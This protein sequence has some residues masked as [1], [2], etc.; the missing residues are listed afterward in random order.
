MSQQVVKSN[1]IISASYELSVL[2]QRLILSCIGQIRRDNAAIS[3]ETLY[4]VSVESLL[5][6]CPTKSNSIYEK[7]AEAARRL[8][9]RSIS[10]QY[11]PDGSK[12]V[13]RKSRFRWVQRVDYIEKEGRIELRFSKDIL[14]Y[15]T[16]LSE[17]FTRYSLADVANMSSSYAIRLYELLVQY[18]DIG[19]REIEL[20]QLRQ[21]FVLENKYPSI[22]DLKKWVIEPAIN[23]INEHSPLQVSWTQRKTG[24][25]VTH[26]LFEWEPKKPKITKKTITMAELSKLAYVGETTEQALSRLKLKLVQ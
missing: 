10:V 16:S 21:W 25:T 5:D 18:N 6:L 17:R 1:H 2:E 12:S 3:D 7:L 15:L 13:G 22:K 4:S 9:E 14:P 8:Y 11:K 20:V 26:L 19:K 23:Q 24:R